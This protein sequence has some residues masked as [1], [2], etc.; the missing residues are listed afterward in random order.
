MRITLFI[1]VHEK[2]KPFKCEICNKSFSTKNSHKVHVVRVHEG[3]K[4]FTCDTCGKNFADAYD[5]KKHNSM[6]HEGV[7]YSCHICTDTFASKQAVHNHVV[8]RIILLPGY[9][10]RLKSLSASKR[11]RKF[12]KI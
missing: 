6:V 12:G 7:R 8:A 4:P 5:L 9:K 3:K 10:T 1:T 2:Q 11:T